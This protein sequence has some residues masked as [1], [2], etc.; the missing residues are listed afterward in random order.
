M[1]FIYICIS[2]S[3]VDH[4]KIIN[5]NLIILLLYPCKSYRTNWFWLS[6]HLIGN[7]KKLDNKSKSIERC[8][9]NKLK[10]ILS[11][12]YYKLI[13][14]LK[15]HSNSSQKL[16]LMMHLTQCCLLRQRNWKSD[17]CLRIGK[18]NYLPVFW[19][20]KKNKYYRWW[21]TAK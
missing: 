13:S 3:T 8:P 16:P 10:T 19:K 2:I 7:C 18:I 11:K 20:G 21:R 17:S 5:N 4:N 15:K 1:R 6:K 12:K 14:M 9:K